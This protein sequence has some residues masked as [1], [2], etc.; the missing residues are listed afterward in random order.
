MYSQLLH[1][2]ILLWRVIEMIA[3][4]SI[5]G[6]TTRLLSGN[7]MQYYFFGLLRRLARWA[8]WCD[9]FKK[10]ITTQRGGMVR[11]GA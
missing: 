10:D 5:G 3:S 4:G 9:I 7:D 1:L 6:M 8:R 2:G 11:D